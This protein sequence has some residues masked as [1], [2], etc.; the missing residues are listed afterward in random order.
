MGG[1][2]MQMQNF[3]VNDGEGI[4]TII[5]MAGCP[6]SCAWCANPE[7]Q[8][9]KNPMTHWV[10]TEEVIKEIR[11]QY[12]FYRYSGGGVTFS[13]GEAT[14][15]LGFLKEM[16]DVLYDEGFNLA[17]ETCGQFVF[18]EVEPVLRKMDLIFMDLKLMNSEKHKQFTGVDNSQILE[19][20]VRTSRLGVPMV[21][22][23]PVINGVNGDDE[24]MEKTFA[25]LRANKMDVGLEFLPYHRYGEGKYKSLGLDLPSESFTIPTEDQLA[26]WSEM[27]KQ[28]GI[29]VVSYK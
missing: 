5:F 10:E 9:L 19:N 27:A 15:Q 24:N 2:I 28:Y 12:L 6:L 7:G 21:V 20:L 3:S 17:I 29:N 22:R 1:Y 13:G 25:F 23:I 26:H 4:R 16:V 18:E 11:H 8:T 14:M